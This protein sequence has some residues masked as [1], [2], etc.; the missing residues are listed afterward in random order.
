MAVSRPP[1]GT[2]RRARPTVRLQFPPAA[3]RANCDRVPAADARLKVA[4]AAKTGPGNGSMRGSISTFT[5]RSGRLP[6]G[7]PH[8]CCGVLRQRRPAHRDRGGV[9][10][11][12][13]ISLSGID[14]P[15]EPL[16]CS[17]PPTYRNPCW[18]TAKIPEL[19]FDT[20][21]LSWRPADGCLVGKRRAAPI[22]ACRRG[23]ST[24]RCRC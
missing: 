5:P 6:A 3:S 10:R 11:V 19:V 7:P 14:S 16:G 18:L 24:L 8:R 13:G 21:F 20:T 4:D 17:A 23:R 12:A 22:P 15:A 1:A 9:R 2:R